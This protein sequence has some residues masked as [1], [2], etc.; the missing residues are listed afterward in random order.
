MNVFP[1][2]KGEDFEIRKRYTILGKSYIIHTR[3]FTPY[4]LQYFHLLLQLIT[5][6]KVLFI[7]RRTTLYKLIK[8][9]LLHHD[10]HHIS[11]NTKY[12]KQP[13]NNNKNNYNIQDILNLTIHWDVCIDSP[14]Q[15]TH[16]DNNEQNR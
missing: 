9:L 16:K 8:L 1:R 6:K 15:N 2:S 13:D 5:T 10:G 12:F 3:I 4:Q 14:K 11:P 7:S